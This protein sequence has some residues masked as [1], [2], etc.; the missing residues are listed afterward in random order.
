MA[1]QASKSAPILPLPFSLPEVDEISVLGELG[2]DEEV[3]LAEESADSLP[4]DC[5]ELESQSD[6]YPDDDGNEI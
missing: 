1:L 6:G 2:D 4:L 3:P 5:V